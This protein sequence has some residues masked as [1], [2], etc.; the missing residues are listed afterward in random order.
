MYYKFLNVKTFG[1]IK[2][3]MNSALITT[4]YKIIV[5]VYISTSRNIHSTL[6]KRWNG[7]KTNYSPREF[8]DQKRSPTREV[9]ILWK[10]KIGIKVRNG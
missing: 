9:F 4:G 10:L 3:E 1:L 6:I 7:D 8:M 5:V 2:P